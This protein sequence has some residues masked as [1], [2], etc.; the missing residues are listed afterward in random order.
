MIYV[1][2]QITDMDYKEFYKK[3]LF[4][5]R[6]IKITDKYLEKRG[7][8]KTKPIG[9]KNPTWY[10]FDD[11]VLGRIHVSVYNNKPHYRLQINHNIGDS[12]YINTV[13]DIKAAVYS[14]V[15]GIQAVKYGKEGNGY[16]WIDVDTKEEEDEYRYNLYCKLIQK[17]KYK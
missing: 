5:K 14:Y 4:P 10:Y 2:I 16:K 12:R 3:E 13:A 9:E 8:H 15:C 6:D 17:I 11:G 1:K 7:W